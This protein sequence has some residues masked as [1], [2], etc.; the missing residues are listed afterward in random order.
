M[1]HVLMDHHTSRCCLCIA[2]FEGSVPGEYDEVGGQ[3]PR[4]VW[5][6]LGR[7]QEFA[8][9]RALYYYEICEVEGAIGRR[10]EIGH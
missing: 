7:P 9:V 5:A 3:V 6:S 1:K 4:S 10:G 2:R 8:S